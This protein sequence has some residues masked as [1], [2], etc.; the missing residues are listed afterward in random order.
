MGQVLGVAATAV[1]SLPLYIIACPF[2]YFSHLLIMV[3]TPSLGGG[4]AGRGL[5]LRPEGDCTNLLEGVLELTL[6]QAHNCANGDD[7]YLQIL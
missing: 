5:T 6:I 7:T 4:I 2:L 3:L 1:T